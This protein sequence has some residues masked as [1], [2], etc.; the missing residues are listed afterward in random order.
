MKCFATVGN[1]GLSASSESIYQTKHGRSRGS[2]R[3]RPHRT[4]S[5]RNKENGSGSFR[6]KNSFK[7]TNVLAITENVKKLNCTVQNSGSSGGVGVGV[8]VG[9]IGIG[10]SAIGASNG[11]NT[12]LNG[13]K[14]FKLSFQNISSNNSSML[15]ASATATAVVA[16]AAAVAAQNKSHTVTFG[17]MPIKVTPAAKNDQTV[18]MDQELHDHDQSSFSCEFSTK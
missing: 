14:L 2:L 10:G 6:R 5:R 3:H 11:S 8:G 1:I 12:T 18:P 15:D 16:A 17:E 13:E 4:S 7:K 9:G